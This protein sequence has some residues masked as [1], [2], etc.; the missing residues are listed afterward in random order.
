MIMVRTPFRISFFGGGSDLPSFY[1]RNGYGAVVSTTINKYMYIMIHPYFHNKI[2][3]KYSRTED[4]KSVEDIQHPIVRECLKLVNIEEGVEIA[5]IADVPAGTGIGSSSSFTVGLLHALYAYKGK[6]ADKQMLAQEARK[7]EI[8][9]LKEPIGKQDQYA[10]SYGGLNYISFNSNETVSVDPVKCRPDIK[11]RL[12]KNLLMFYVGNER[13]AN[14][15]LKKQSESMEQKDKYDRVKKMVSL[16]D[17]VRCLLTNGEVSNFGELLHKGWLYKKGV[18]SSISNSNIDG[19]YEKALTT[20]ADGGKILGAGGGGFMLFY[21]K[22]EYQN[23]LRTE[24]KLRQLPFE[25]DDE[26]S[27]IIYMD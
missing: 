13:K 21:C 24:M 26:G 15:I 12:Q 10:V 25:F 7:I 3:V 4:V 14:S 20:G 17:E 9:I 27:K 19:C 18:A 1:R 22:P 5:S 16:A 11:E 8:D 6:Q 23:T 2:R